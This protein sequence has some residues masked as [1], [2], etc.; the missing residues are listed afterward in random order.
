ML[1]VIIPTHRRSFIL[2][3]TLEHIAAQTTVRE[4]EVI[5]VSDG[6][7]AQARAMCEQ[8]CWDFPLRYEEIPKAHQGVARNHGV[9]LATGD[10][11][12]FIGDD[13]FLEP[14]ACALHI[15]THEGVRKLRASH[16]EASAL[17]SPAVLGFI[18]WDPDCG[19]TPVMRFLERSGW[20]FGYPKLARYGGRLVPPRMQHWFTYTGHIS[21]ATDVARRFPFREDVS[22]Y[23]WEDVEW[24][25][26]LREA[27]V[28]LL[29]EP[30]AKALHH[31]H[32]ETDDSL[33]RLETLGRSAVVMEKL[34]PALRLTPK[35]F[36]KVAY[37][38]LSLLPTFAGTHRAA[39]LRGL[40]LGESASL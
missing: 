37:R 19:I 29:Y 32:L 13:M 4:L 14:E 9:R 22:L 17:A 27:G 3:R 30:W 15:G 2:K 34:N 16:A 8:A 23:G 26:R 39:F 12:L 21:V 40:R 7:D 31:H 35:G 5:V 25:L 24:G 38:L 20:Q 6:E 1:S 33:K 28:G 10:I 11:V 36:K 18:T